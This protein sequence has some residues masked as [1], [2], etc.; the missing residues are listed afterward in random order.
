MSVRKSVINA[1]SNQK[2]F[3]YLFLTKPTNDSMYKPIMKLLNTYGES[4]NTA[5]FSEYIQ[6]FNPELKV[7]EYI[8]LINHK[9][10]YLLDKKGVNKHRHDL[11]KLRQIIMIKTNP[12]IFALSFGGLSTPLLL[13]SFRRSELIMFLLSQVKSN[14]PKVVVTRS[15]GIRIFL[16]DKSSKQTIQKV[17]K[18]DKISKKGE[19]SEMSKDLI[20]QLEKNVQL[21]NFANAINSGYIKMRTSTFLIGTRWEERFVVLTN[22]GLLYFADP[23]QAPLDLFPVLDCEIVKVHPSEVKGNECTFKLVY[24]TKNVTFQCSNG[25]EFAN[26]LLQ[27]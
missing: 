5:V 1:T 3:D 10:L 14:V 22:I 19:N 9:S 26:W 12:C 6:S 11:P 23:H 13:Q 4:G 27:I 7:T 15:S 20:K 17:I 25:A 24:L 8:L 2:D 18:F 16:Q 21:N